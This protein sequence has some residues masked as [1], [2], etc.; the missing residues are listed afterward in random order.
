MGSCEEAKHHS[1]KTN[2]Y[3][4]YCTDRKHPLLHLPSHACG[5]T[6]SDVTCPVSRCT[7]LK[8]DRSL[9]CE[10]HTCCVRNCPKVAEPTQYCEERES[11]GT[12]ASPEKC[13]D[14]FKIAVPSRVAK[15][16][17]A[18]ARSGRIA[19][20]FALCVSATPWCW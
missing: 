17:V 9:F 15:T 12:G 5:L 1:T 18:G 2:E 16:P 7:A 8:A 3:L 20:S 10:D 13:S 14:L 6:P 11:T 4:A 19:G